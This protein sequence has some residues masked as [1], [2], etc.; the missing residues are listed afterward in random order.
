MQ[1]I[2]ALLKI[3]PAI[4]Q[5]AIQSVHAIEMGFQAVAEATGSSVAGQGAQK[6]AVA[7][8]G[9]AA[10]MKAESEL[11]A[12]I[13]VDLVVKVFAAVRDTAVAALKKIGIFKGSTPP[14]A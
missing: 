8:A 14:A 1:T 9:I 10:V 7:E 6:A 13:P 4:F 5:A 3:L 12:Q 2:L 11:A